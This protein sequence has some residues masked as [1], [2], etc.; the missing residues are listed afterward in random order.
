MKKITFVLLACLMST[1][2]NA[3]TEVLELKPSES[4]CIAG[5]GPGQDAAINPYLGE[6]SVAIV[7]NVGENPFNVRIQR[8]GVVIR[9]LM[10]K[11]KDKKEINLGPKDEL[12]FDSSMGAKAKVSFKK[13]NSD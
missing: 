10:I 11:R 8:D 7:K 13:A 9:T 1:A 3:Q 4:M 6:A 12:Y 5:K 2:A